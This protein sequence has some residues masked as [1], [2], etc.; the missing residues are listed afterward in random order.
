MHHCV[1]TLCTRT[2][3]E[4][5]IYAAGAVSHYFMSR[6]AVH[7][8]SMLCAPIKDKDRIIAVIQAIN[9]VNSDQGKAGGWA[10]ACVV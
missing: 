6:D 9:K 7:R 1:V 3:R 8:Q 2:T 5:W 10:M 4:Y